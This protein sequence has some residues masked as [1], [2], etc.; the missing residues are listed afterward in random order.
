MEA[1][2]IQILGSWGVPGHGAGLS[3]NSLAGVGPS[4]GNPKR[5]THANFH[6][7]PLRFNGFCACFTFCRPP[8]RFVGVWLLPDE[9]STYLFFVSC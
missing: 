4:P 9:L 5:K 1:F 6:Q 8:G 7:N 3:K 2:F